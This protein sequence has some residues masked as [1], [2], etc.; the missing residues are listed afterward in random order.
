MVSH[1]VERI[2][3]LGCLEVA[4]HLFGVFLCAPKEAADVGFQICHVTG[5]FAAHGVTLTSLFS[6]S[7]GLSSG[8]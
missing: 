8:L 3:G 4:A 7:S 2:P 1:S 6:N 5:A